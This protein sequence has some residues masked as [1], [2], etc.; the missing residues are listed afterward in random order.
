MTLY[1]WIKK[2]QTGLRPHLGGIDSIYKTLY[3]TV[4]PVNGDFDDGRS[5]HGGVFN[6]EFSLNG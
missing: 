3:S 1:S 5:E 2:R 6:L 4:C